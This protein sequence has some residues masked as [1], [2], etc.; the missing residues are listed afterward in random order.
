MTQ[1]NPTDHACSGTASAL[2]RAYCAAAISKMVYPKL[3]R[4]KVQM[5]TPLV[6]L[7]IPCYNEVEGLPQ[8]LSRLD[9]MRA[10]GSMPRWE[11]LFVNDGS[12]DATGSV[13]NHMMDHYDWIRVVHHI[14]NRGLG[15][16]L[17]TG[18]QHADSP[19]IC[20]MDSDLSSDN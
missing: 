17:R 12:Q 16:A 9:T 7:I 2:E 19:Y 10:T 5:S 6:T 20:T 18:F 3:F 4:W 11:V 13:L 15:A 1:A 14:N 8:L